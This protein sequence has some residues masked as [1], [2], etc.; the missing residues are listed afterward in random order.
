MQGNSILVTLYYVGAGAIG[1]TFILI[2]QSC[3]FI[4]EKYIY[5]LDIL[6]KLVNRGQLNIWY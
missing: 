1:I 2:D 3:V 6:N 5:C 4:F